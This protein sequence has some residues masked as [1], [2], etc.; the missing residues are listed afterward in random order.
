M[1]ELRSAL[2]ARQQKGE[3]D[4]VFEG[5]GKRKYT[6]KEGKRGAYSDPAKVLHVIQVQGV[7]SPTEPLDPHSEQNDWQDG[8]SE[9]HPQHQQQQQQQQQQHEKQQHH[10]HKQKQPEE[11]PGDHK[12]PEVQAKAREL[13]VKLNLPVQV[14]LRIALLYQFTEDGIGERI[15]N[16]YLDAIKRLTA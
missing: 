16:V 2:A 10:Q 6:F 3:E 9:E 5:Y 12:S 15:A 13:E 11:A 4:Q 14:A 1:A 8:D 7:E